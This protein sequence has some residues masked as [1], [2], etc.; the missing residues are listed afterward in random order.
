MSMINPD[1][2]KA[3]IYK[4]VK[5]VL[6][7]GNPLDQLYYKAKN[8]AKFDNEIL[9]VYL[10]SIKNNSLNI[11][12]DIYWEAHSKFSGK[13]T[14]NFSPIIIGNINCNKLSICGGIIVGNVTAKRMNVQYSNK[15]NSDNPIIYGD[16]NIKDVLMVKG[17]GL[18]GR[19][20]KFVISGN[21]TIKTYIDFEQTAIFSKKTIIE[22]SFSFPQIFA[23]EVRGKNCLKETYWGNHTADELVNQYLHIKLKKEDYGEYG[24]FSPI[25]RVN[26]L[27]NK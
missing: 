14:S 5:D 10:G 4:E 26:R 16:L 6:P 15:K 9:F 8:K 19:L 20:F 2:I 17:K 24:F 21:A 13:L 22:T 25:F 27:I 1:N 11:I 12:D 23:S 18:W 3:L 7:K